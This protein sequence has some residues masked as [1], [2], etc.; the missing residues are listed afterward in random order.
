MGGLFSTPPEREPQFIIPSKST[1]TKTIIF[2]HGIGAYAEEFFEI[3]EHPYYSPID[4]NTKVILLNAPIRKVTAAF[5]AS[6]YSWFNIKSYKLNEFP[7]VFDLTQAN[8]TSDR[9]VDIINSEV[10]ENLNGD[11][12]DSLNITLL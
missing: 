8:E 1:H 9:I 4:D 10:S 2:L 11:Y 6:M 12:T 5:N 3:F 7:S